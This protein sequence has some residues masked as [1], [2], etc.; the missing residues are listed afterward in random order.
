MCKQ[1]ADRFKLPPLILH[2]FSAP[3]EASVLAQSSRASLILRGYLP[4]QLVPES[5]L[6]QNLI[7]GRFA[8]LRMLFYVGKDLGRWM[9]QCVEVTGTRHEFA[10]LG[11]GREAFA[12]LLVEEAPANVHRKLELWGVL[13]YRALFRRAIGLHC[14]FE[15]VPPAQCLT[16]DFLK[17]YHRH[18]D[19]WFESWVLCR[20]LPAIDWCEFSFDLYASGEYA[21]MLERSWNVQSEG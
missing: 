19:R 5:E 15:D 6:E 12:N 20:P 17:R 11:L 21:L 10:H 16:A 18:A 8:E 9:E 4:S 2:P 1:E 3:E 14:V 7:R 13:D